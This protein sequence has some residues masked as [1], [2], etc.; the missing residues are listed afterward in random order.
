MY[1]VVKGTRKVTLNSF[2]NEVKTYRHKKS[3]HRCELDFIGGR[4][5]NRTSDHKDC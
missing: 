5:W 2:Y 1:L 4:N 3:P